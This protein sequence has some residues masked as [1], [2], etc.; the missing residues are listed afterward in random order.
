M[1]RKQIIPA[2]I[3]LII[4][5]TAVVS[6]R[7]QELV[8][9]KSPGKIDRHADRG[10]NLKHFFHPFLATSVYT[11][12]GLDQV[13][14][15]D[16]PL[17][18][19]LS[20]GIRYKYKV[21]RS[22]AWV[23]ESGIERNYFRLEG[24]HP[25]AATDSVT[26]Q[27]QSVRIAGLFAGTFIRIRLG[28][29][30]N[31]LGNYLDFGITAQAPIRKSLITKDIENIGGMDVTHVERTSVS[32]LKNLTRASYSA[33]FRIGFDRFSLLASYR[34]SRVLNKDSGDDLPAM[35]VGIEFSP[36]RY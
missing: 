4:L 36:I 23:A 33:C 5:C 11:P 20:A 6:L 18:N 15:T 1:G 17:S 22:L 16:F 13:I 28:Q 14:S 31:Y 9:E 21:T 35:L 24:N 19:R 30:G 10:P 12:Y 25:F 2:G 26:H 34:L 8:F 32:S 3:L 29:K 7:G 27:S